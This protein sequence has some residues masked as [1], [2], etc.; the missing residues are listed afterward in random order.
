MTKSRFLIIGW[1]DENHSLNLEAKGMKAIR[2]MIDDARD[3]VDVKPV[4]YR[5]PSTA[6]TTNAAFELAVRVCGLDPSQARRCRAWLR[7]RGMPD[8]VV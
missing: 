7:A 5:L 6:R 4:E 8:V 2:L 1:R 3:G